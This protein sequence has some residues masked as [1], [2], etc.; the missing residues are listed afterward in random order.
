MGSF[1]PSIRSVTWAE[2]SPT[3]DLTED[4]VPFG[5]AVG[6]AGRTG[7]LRVLGEG[8]L[9]LTVTPRTPGYFDGG[10]DLLSA[11]AFDL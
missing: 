9:A 10:G 7:P 3:L 1:R 5:V 8:P 6:R 2:N 11:T 4:G